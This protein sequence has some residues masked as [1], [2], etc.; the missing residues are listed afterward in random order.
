[1][2]WWVPLVAVVGLVAFCL[3]LVPFIYAFMAWRMRKLEEK[4][5]RECPEELHRL[6]TA[7]AFQRLADAMRE[8][9]D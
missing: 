9:R 8:Y 7:R 3:L 2:A 5:E 1:M 4:M 6:R